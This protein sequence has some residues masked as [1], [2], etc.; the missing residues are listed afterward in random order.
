MLWRFFYAHFCGVSKRKN[1]NFETYRM[2][3][4]EVQNDNLRASSYSSEVKRND[5]ECLGAPYLYVTLHT[6]SGNVLKYSR[7]GC[8]LDDAVL[9]DTDHELHYDTQLRSM[10]IGRVR[11]K[12]GVLFVAD[13]SNHN[14]QIVYFDNCE[15]DPNSKY[16]G[17]RRYLGKVVDNFNNPGASHAY[18]L[19]TDYYG[20]IYGSF[21]HTGAV[22]RFTEDNFKPMDLPPAF[23]LSRR[24]DYFEGTFM[25]FGS[26]REHYHEDEGCAR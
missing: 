10:M 17:K 5:K 8:L 2:G 20:N 14:S 7:D 1:Q 24:E 9:V 13:G 3:S 12:S 16:F 6:S 25:Q 22:L 26:P 19:S 23:Y 15:S 11:G 18:G 21:Q 4:F